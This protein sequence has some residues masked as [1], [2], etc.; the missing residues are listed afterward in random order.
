MSLASGIEISVCVK[1][2]EFGPASR[3]KA[4]KI[5]TRNELFINTL[6]QIQEITSWRSSQEQKSADTHVSSVSDWSSFVNEKAG[7]RV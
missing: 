4:T 2:D 6:N 3:T 7:S 5:G 1:A